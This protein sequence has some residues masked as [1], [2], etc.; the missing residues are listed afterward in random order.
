MFANLNI[1]SNKMVE[2]PINLF[3]C[4]FLENNKIK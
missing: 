1:N 2:G 4:R 3:F